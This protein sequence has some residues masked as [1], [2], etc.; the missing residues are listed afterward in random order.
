[1]S[2]ILDVET[3]NAPEFKSLPD[4]TEAELRIVKAEMK[5]SGKGD[6][7]LVLRFDI[8]AEP[9]SKDIN[10]WI[11]LPKNGDDEKT[12]AQKQNR[13]KTLKAAFK[14]APVGPLS[15]EDMEGAKGW[16]ILGEEESAEYGSQNRVKRFV[17]G[18]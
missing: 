6:P 1:M 7:A 10:F 16:A 4:G 9:Y 18:Q 15:A 14:L 8:P 13:L 11:M 12:V 2:F 5:N 17:V 3:Q